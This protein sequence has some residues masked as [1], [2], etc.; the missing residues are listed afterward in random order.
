ML[1]SLATKL[2]RYIRTTS[3]S[4]KEFDKLIRKEKPLWFIDTVSVLKGKLLDPKL[5]DRPSSTSVD[6]NLKALGLA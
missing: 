5:K 3:T 1:R 4:H 6:P 2:T